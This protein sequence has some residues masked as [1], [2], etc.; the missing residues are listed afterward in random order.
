MDEMSKK[1]QKDKK[2]HEDKKDRFVVVFFALLGFVGSV[3][4]YR[5]SSAPPIIISFFLA[6]GVAAL[7][8]G[9][10]GGIEG[11]TLELRWLKL[12]GSI[13]ALV[14]VALIV[15]RSLEAGLQAEE[16]RRQGEEIRRQAEDARRQI[17]V[18]G[19]DSIVGEWRWVYAAG[20]WE[21]HLDFSKQ[22]NELVFIGHNS[23]MTKP[24]HPPIFD[25]TNGKARLIDGNKLQL[26]ADVVDHVHNDRFHWVSTAPLAL[27]PA[28]RGELRI[29][30]GR[31]TADRWGMMIYK[32]P[33][34]SGK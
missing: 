12:G 7:V 32:W 19:D 6:T 29:D 13:A 23:D 20:G 30:E 3:V 34:P 17:H 9:F 8:F 14:G 33:P 5:T 16:V 31:A 22:N 26:E 28:F 1:D 2:D 24:G 27:T 21:G 18:S 15:N 10:L 4:L 11:A 25:L